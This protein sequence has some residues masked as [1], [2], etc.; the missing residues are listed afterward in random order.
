[1]LQIDVGKW[2]TPAVGGRIGYQ[3]IKFKNANLQ[4]MK[5]QFIHADFMYNLTHNL[6]CNEYGLSKFDVIPYIGVGMIHNSSN[7]P[8]YFLTD[9][10]P[11]AT[12]RLLSAMGSSFAI[13]LLTVFILSV[14]SVV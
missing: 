2:F 8:G 12:I 13:F 10:V 5:Y 9:N 1:M 6:Q 14:K 11:S 7:I 3:G 4:S